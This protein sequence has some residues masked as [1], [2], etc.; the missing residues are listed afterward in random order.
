[1][2]SLD[3]TSKTFCFY[4]MKLHTIKKLSKLVGFMKKKNFHK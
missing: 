4:I 1:M 3:K 2:I